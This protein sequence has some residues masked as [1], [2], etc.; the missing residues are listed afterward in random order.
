MTE[1]DKKASWKI[2]GKGKGLRWHIQREIMGLLSRKASNNSDVQAV[3][4]MMRGLS[5]KK[6]VEL[7]R[8]LQDAKCV[9]QEYDKVFEGYFWIATSLGI[10]VYLG[11][12]TALPLHIAERLLINLEEVE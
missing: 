12:I 1:T 2:R 6:T 4:T 10:K 7:L 3:M 5:H 9:I 8:E 11:E